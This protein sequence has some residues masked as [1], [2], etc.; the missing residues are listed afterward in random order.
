MSKS[1]N[2]FYLIIGAGIVGLSVAHCLSKIT[3]EKIIIID[4]EKYLGAHASGRNSG[5]LHAGFYYTPGTL[6]AKL[7]KEGNQRLNEYCKEKGL[8]INECGKVLVCKNEKDL[9]VLKELENRAVINNVEVHII[10]EKQ[11][12]EIEPYAKTYKKALYS[13]TTAVVDPKEILNS[14]AEDAKRS[15]V[16]LMR[17][18]KFVNLK[19]NIAFTSI[20]KINYKFLINCAGLY[21][22]HIAQKMGIGNNYKILPFKGIYFS[23]K[24]KKSQLVRSNIYPIPNLNL[25]F[26]GVHITKSI[27]G[28]LYVGPTAIP[29]LGRE[30][31]HLFKN[32]NKEILE[33]L[34]YNLWFFLKN[35]YNYRRFTFNEIK[36]YC[37][38]IL[39]KEVSNFVNGISYHDIT[40]SLKVGIRAQLI[41]IK[42]KKLIMDFVVKRGENSVHI[43][44]AISPAFTC[45]I[46]FA[47][48]VVKTFIM[49]NNNWRN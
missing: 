9:E 28:K 13:P 37:K 41:D 47:K 33:I 44:N 1:L 31:Y 26:L 20:G 7:T 12:K 42:K 8:K 19:N 17:G 48:Y 11:L 6:K 10:D 38:Y 39:Y 16:I 3:E 24:D 25:P 29:A 49:S 30:N 36:K 21:A 45:S 2:T 4:K 5:V 40:N 14:M 46:P 15:G 22:D 23:I 34:R 27:N 35:E 43:L 32:I 18:V